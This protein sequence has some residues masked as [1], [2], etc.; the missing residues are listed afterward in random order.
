SATLADCEDNRTELHDLVG[1]ESLRSPGLDHGVEIRLRLG[2]LRPRVA[3]GRADARANGAPEILDAEPAPDVQDGMVPRDGR[4]AHA[5]VVV[6]RPPD[7]DGALV[8]QRM[9]ARSTAAQDDQDAL[10]LRRSA[11]AQNEVVARRA[12]APRASSSSADRFAP[13]PWSDNTRPR[14]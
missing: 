2:A 12:N 11:H 4:V 13:A 5:D 7:P 1:S 8:R 3:R 14:P 6:A 10:G 9:R